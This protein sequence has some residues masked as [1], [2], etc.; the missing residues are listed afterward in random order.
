MTDY[1]LT[2]IANVGQDPLQPRHLA[3][4]GA[5]L[6]IECKP[7]W[8]AQNEACDLVFP[9]ALS[10]TQITVE[11]RA[12]L[13]GTCIDAVCTPAKN[14]RKRL[15]IS[16]MDSTIIDQEC[17]DELGEALGIGAQIGKIT[18]AV[19]HAEIRFTEA[20]RQRV[21]M[22]KGMDYGLLERVYKER[23]TLKTGA[24]T[25]VRTMRHHA[26]HC[27]LVSGGFSYFASRVANTA[28]FDDYQANALVF[29]AGKMTGRVTEP[30]LGRVKKLEILDALCKAK[31]L[32]PADVLAAGD[33]ANDIDMIGAA[34]MGV[35][36]HGSDALKLHANATIDHAD[37]TA[38]LY[39][40]GYRKSQFVFD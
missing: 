13:A 12:A 9:S 16:D 24:R 34:G 26:A 40:Q 28:G 10:A 4:V 18:R 29:E 7:D 15:L 3:L 37:L 17:I 32:S 38:L 1:A 39:I 22:M 20:L 14:R 5:R 6:N 35:A 27:V 8:L 31:G 2:L 19:V 30:I 21:A 11:A 23:I 25:L 33:G 36:F